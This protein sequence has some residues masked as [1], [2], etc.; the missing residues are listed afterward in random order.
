MTTPAHEL[1]LVRH[2]DVPRHKVWRCWTEPALITRWFTPPP[3]KTVAAEMDLRSGGSTNVTME[4]PDGQ[5]VENPGV[6]LDVVPNEKLVFTDA[7][8]SAWVPSAKPFMVG[9]IELS[10][11]DGGTRYV[12]RALHWTAEDKETHE[13]MGFHEGWGVAADQLEALAK[14]L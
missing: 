1:T 8:T 2:M 5:R 7:F 9:I 3:W 6:Y 12:A 4:G 10:D 14:T 13:K 11:E